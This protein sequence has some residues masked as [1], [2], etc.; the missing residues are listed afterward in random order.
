MG[1]AIRATRSTLPKKVHI[2]IATIALLIS[3]CTGSE[4]PADA[5]QNETP[6]ATETVSQARS[7]QASWLVSSS[8]AGYDDVGSYVFTEAVDDVT[9]RYLVRSSQH[10][11]FQTPDEVVFC[12]GISRELPY[13]ATAKRAQGVPHVLS[14]PLQRLNEWRPDQLFDLASYR[15]LEFTAKQDE[16]NWSKEARTINNIATEC[17]VVTGDSPAARP[18]FTACFTTDERR[19]LALLDVQGDAA[20]EVLLLEDTALTADSFTTGFEEFYEARPLLQERLLEIY[21]ELPVERKPADTD[22]DD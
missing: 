7:Y 5:E 15:T 20:T 12:A 9:G 11:G 21:P 3:A 4:D 10:L 18:G 14:Y 13:C 1:F 2:L 17:F 22:T 6:A 16:Q 19:L 8:A